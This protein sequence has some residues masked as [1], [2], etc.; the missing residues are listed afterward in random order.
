MNGSVCKEAKERL[1]VSARRNEVSPSP[2]QPFGDALSNF[3]HSS[4]LAP[5]MDHFNLLISLAF[6]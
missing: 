6:F 2:L 4:C 3:R 5:L 1:L